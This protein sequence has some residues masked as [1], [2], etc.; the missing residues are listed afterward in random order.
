MPSADAQHLLQRI[1]S[2][3][4]LLI[5]AEDGPDAGLNLLTGRENAFAIRRRLVILIDAQRFDEAAALIRLRQL[6]AQWCD[7]AAFVLGHVGD[8]N[9]ARAVLVWAREHA[10]ETAYRRTSLLFAQAWYQHSFRA[11]TERISQ[12]IPGEVT[13]AERL[14]LAVIPDVLEPIVAEAQARG[15]ITT[16]LDTEAVTLVATVTVWLGERERLN[17]LFSLLLTRNP[18]PLFIADFAL[19]GLIA[20]P[21]NLPARLRADHKDNW[22]TQYLACAVEGMSL[23]RPKEALASALSL[24]D[25][26]VSDDERE[27]LHGLLFELAAR[28]GPE[29]VDQ[30]S[31]LASTLLSDERRRKLSEAFGLLMQDKPDLAE[32]L[33]NETRDELDA[34]WLQ[35]YARLL[36]LR[37]EDADA[38]AY[39]AKATTIFPH[40][41]VLE[42][43]AAVALQAGHLLDAA[44]ALERLVAV[45]PE[46]I[47]ARRQLAHLYGSLDDPIQAAK[48][49]AVLHRLE[50]EHLMDAIAYA[51]ALALGGDLQGSLAVYDTICAAPDTAPRDAVVQRAVILRTF[52]RSHEAFCS[53]HEFKERFWNDPD[54][55]RA[56]I[57]LSFGAEAE[58]EGDAALARLRELQEEGHADP[59]IL[60]TA[61]EDDIINH[62]RQEHEKAAELYRRVTQGVFP[63]LLADLQIG[64]PSYAAWG[65]RTQPL[66]WFVE[67]TVERGKYGVYATNGFARDEGTTSRAR[68]WQP[69]HCPPPG[70]PVVADLSALL[71]LHRLDLLT[72][73]ADYFGRILIP[74]AYLAHSVAETGQLVLH[75]P[76]QKTST[77][78]IKAA[79][80]RS[81]LK[82]SEPSPSTAAD[83]VRVD[84]FAEEE[85][86]P[87]CYRLRDVMEALRRLGRVPDAK[88]HE[89]KTVA[90]AP[91]AE[92]SGLAPITPTAQVWMSLE[93]LKL[94]GQFGVLQDALTAFRVS[95]LPQERDKVM[96]DTQTFQHWEELYRWQGEL[97]GTIRQ[98]TRFVPKAT[99]TRPHTDASGGRR[100]AGNRHDGLEREISIASYYLA[101]ESEAPLLADDR[102]NQM[103]VFGSVRNQ[104]SSRAF[105]TAELITALE[106]A[107][108]ID[109]GRAADC[110]L[111]LLRWR[112]RFLVAPTGV[113]HT[114]ASRFASS[115]PGRDLQDVA[116]YV[117]DAMR[118]PGLPA[119]KL[120][121]KA[122]ATLAERYYQEWVKTVTEFVMGIWKDPAFSD[123][124]AAFLTSWA[125]HQLLPSPPAVIATGSSQLVQR[126]PLLVMVNA[127]LSSCT[128]TDRVRANA[129]IRALS[130]SLGLNEH[131]YLKVLTEAVNRV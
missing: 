1:E 124:A 86:P 22:H 68:N 78:Q 39:L 6:H 97:W 103:L 102:S 125:G 23:D 21:P 117:H 27:R 7:K 87:S 59:G 38:A 75:Q 35:M 114:L 11:R 5:A 45:M 40:P 62:F 89:L 44:A 2:L 115:P 105:G 9:A 20:A 77:D 46:N 92:D 98:D 66:R 107:G 88:Y 28:L 74:S 26:A 84:E 100:A 83:I 106:T 91:S 79:L 116:F 37:G 119:A 112:Y 130:V 51:N 101:L 17:A 122:M 95:I 33:L 3:E 99:Y 47:S 36:L 49:L 64:V 57:D 67:D 53:L 12:I 10:G 131:E 56:F 58:G 31:P 54:Y 96:R 129:G 65:A 128:I 82:V 60:R 69:L 94:L 4:A 73:T 121:P 50:P 81:L 85:T 61:T 41:D 72:S 52:G 48:H 90:H 120:T 32:P 110:F 126:T 109:A 34:T 104:G 13:D 29:A 15:R 43:A 70:V 16:T 24:V 71:T 25:D 55:V 8:L 111:Q 118:D 76:S 108:H 42:F 93:T 63:W 123:D 127:L 80:D 19:Q 18:V 113:L 30:I 14:D